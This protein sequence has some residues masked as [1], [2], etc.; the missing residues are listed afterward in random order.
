MKVHAVVV[1]HDHARRLMDA[2][3]LWEPRMIWIEYILGVDTGGW[4]VP[5]FRMFPDGRFERLSKRRASY[6]ALENMRSEP[7]ESVELQTDRIAMCSRKQ[8]TVLVWSTL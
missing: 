5:V 7:S 3:L 6:G 8:P 4:D 2:A 1:D